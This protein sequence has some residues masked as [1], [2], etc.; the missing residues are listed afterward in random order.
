[1]HLHLDFDSVETECWN[2]DPNELEQELGIAAGGAVLDAIFGEILRRPLLSPEEELELLKRAQQG[3]EEAQNRLIESNLR[4]VISVARRYVRPGLPLEDLVQ[5]GA[6][7]LIRAIRNFDVGRGLRFSTYAIHWIRQSVGRAADAQT[8]MIR[9]PNHA[10][11]SLR[12]IERTR[13]ELRALLGKEPTHEEIAAHLGMPVSKVAR[14]ARYARANYSLE[15]K[16]RE[17]Q[18]T[19]LGG[20]LASPEEED[21][22]AI[23]IERVWLSEI[24]S[25]I[26]THLTSGERWAIY[27][28]LGLDVSDIPPGHTRRLSRERVRQLEKQALAKLRALA[29]EYFAEK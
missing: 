10:V 17:D 28:H 15:H 2:S 13:N 22:E 26:D 27:R 19:P 1:M 21:P 4:L 24:F 29:R 5:E 11:D 8:N 14:L 18:D 25:I 12:K 3:D 7:G 6:I 23:A 16:A 9:L 20:L